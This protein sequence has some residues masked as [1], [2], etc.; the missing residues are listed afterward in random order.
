MIPPQRKRATLYIVLIFLCGV[1]TGTATSKLWMNWG[2]KSVSAKADSQP[3]SPRH[4]VEKFTRELSLSPEQAKQLN[5]ILDET[6]KGY[7]EHEAQIET[8]RQ[9][10]R[11]RI[12]EILN[13]E[14]KAKYEE[15]L[16]TIERNRKRHP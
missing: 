11:N 15:I 10:G 12:R 8:I 3:S 6:H 5:D 9:E 1:L 16:A 2:L 4:T 7:R 14:Q 13:P